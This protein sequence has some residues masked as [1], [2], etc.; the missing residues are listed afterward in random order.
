MRSRFDAYITRLQM[1]CSII[2]EDFVY[3]R[4]RH[5]RQYGW[6]WALLTTPE[7]LLGRDA[8]ECD[9]TPAESYD[10]MATHLAALLPNATPRQI[11]RLLK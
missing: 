1:G 2:T 8:C 7:A 6:G 3:P 11:Q 9:R 5:G 4:D 10:R